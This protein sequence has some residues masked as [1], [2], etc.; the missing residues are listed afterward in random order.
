[1]NK[2]DRLCVKKPEGTTVLDKKDHH[3]LRMGLP[4]RK[5][6]SVCIP[7]KGDVMGNL[8]CVKNGGYVFFVKD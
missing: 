8:K 5:G 6:E 7:V 4:H 1:V 2:K 3:N